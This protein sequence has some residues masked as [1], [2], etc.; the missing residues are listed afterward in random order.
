MTRAHLNSIMEKLDKQLINA[1][2]K[3][4]EIQAHIKALKGIT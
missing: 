4:S 3:V 2:I 1:Q